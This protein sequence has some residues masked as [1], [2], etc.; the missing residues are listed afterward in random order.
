MLNWQNVLK[1]KVATQWYNY[2]PKL[3]RNPMLRLK[4]NGF[5]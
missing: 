2:F 4:L 1:K 3:K 5:S